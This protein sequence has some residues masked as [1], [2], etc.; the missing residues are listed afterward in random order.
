MKTTIEKFDELAVVQ[1]E[2][3]FTLDTADRFRREVIE[4]MEAKARDFVLDLKQVEF[5]DSVALETLLW[6]QDQSAQRLGQVRLAELSESVAT[7][8]RMTRLDK[9]FDTH[10]DVDSAVRSLR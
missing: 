1:I 4:Q 7:I 5:M 9:R 6:L 8:L 2:G 3:E 10:D